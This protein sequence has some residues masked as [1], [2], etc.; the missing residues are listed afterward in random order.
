MDCLLLHR[1]RFG[2]FAGIVSFGGKPGNSLYADEPAYQAL[3]GNYPA[4][5]L[6]PATLESYGTE[7]LDYKMAIKTV[8]DVVEA[9]TH[10]SYIRFGHSGVS[11]QRIKAAAFFTGQWMQP[12]S[13]SMRRLRLPMGLQFGLGAEI[14]IITQKLH[15]RGPMGLRRWLPTSGLWKVT[16]R[17]EKMNKISGVLYFYSIFARKNKLIYNFAYE[18]YTNVFDLGDLK[19]ALEAFEI[20]NDRYKYE[21]LTRHKTCLLIFFNNSLR[22]PEYA[23]LPHNL[24]IWMLIVLDVNQGCL[25]TGNWTWRDY[26]WWQKWA[27]AGGYSVMASYYDVI[28]VRSFARFE[29][30]KMI[31]TEK[32]WI[33]I[34]V[35]RFSL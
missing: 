9:V 4:E 11:W 24:G 35:N 5:L 7:F 27:S 8:D 16:D 29:V 12:V 2:R 30:R 18:T 28:G 6:Q 17:Y 32:I 33:V 26:G 13:M 25:E 20:K 10:I 21:A 34:P 19:T 31:T 1:D 15:A 23:E 3:E 22:T 14:G